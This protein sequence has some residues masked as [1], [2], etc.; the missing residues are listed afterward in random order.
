MAVVMAEDRALAR[1]EEVAPC[2]DVPVEPPRELLVAA[3][4]RELAQ[5][6]LELEAHVV[7][8]G[9]MR[10]DDSVDA[11]VAEL[12][13]AHPVE[14]RQQLAHFARDPHALVFA[15]RGGEWLEELP[16]ELRQHQH[17]LRVVRVEDPRGRHVDLVPLEQA[18]D[19]DLLPE[20]PAQELR[21]HL[22]HDP[23]ADADQ[24]VVD[25]AVRAACELIDRGHVEV[26]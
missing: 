7:E 22:Q 23:L 11:D 15:K 18:V 1:C 20:L 4:L 8:V 26:G 2:L 13:E 9:R 5:A 14:A 25:R 3:E 10:V 16:I 21:L 24:D 12:V 17:S 19:E 6:L